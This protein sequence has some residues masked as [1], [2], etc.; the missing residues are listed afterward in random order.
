MA[1]WVLHGDQKDPDAENGWDAD[2]I[3][4]A[5]TGEANNKT[6]NL[7]TPLPVVITYLTA[8]ADEDG[9]THFFTDIYGYDKELETALAKGR[10]YAQAET[11]VNPKLTVGETE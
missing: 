2:K 4:V 7:K 6:V 1:L 5:M 10:P 8:N 3:D 9:T 11:K